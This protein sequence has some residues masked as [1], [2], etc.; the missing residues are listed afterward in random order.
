MENNQY[1]LLI[2]KEKNKG[3]IFLNLIATQDPIGKIY[4]NNIKNYVKIIIPINEIKNTSYN[5]LKD[6]TIGNNRI[7]FFH[8]DHKLVMV[9]DIFI[10]YGCLVN[11]SN[12][13]KASI[14]TINDEKWNYLIIPQK[15]LGGDQ[16]SSTTM[17]VLDQLYEFNDP[18]VVISVPG[19]SRWVRNNERTR[20]GRTR[21][22]RT[23]N[24]GT[25]TWSVAKIKKKEQVENR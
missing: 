19:C 15:K 6:N 22:E 2:L 20:T 24:E 18:S 11:H 9:T 3:N 16:T 25:R 5:T 14:T 7:V 1:K 12:L 13:I 4:H 17:M 23:R 21:N 10:K 8:E